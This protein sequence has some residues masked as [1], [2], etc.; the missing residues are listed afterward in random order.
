MCIE[1]LKSK[2]EIE[3]SRRELQRRRLSFTTPWWK[4]LARKT[5]LSRAIDIGDEL[6]SWDVLKTIHFIE[7]NVSK[8]DPILDMGAFA[9]EVLCILRDLGYSN[10]AGIDLN[11]SIKKMPHAESV[12]YNVGDFMHTEF[13]SESFQAISAISVMEHGFNGQKLFA[14]I[15]RL[16]RPGGY[17]IASFDYWPHKLDTSSISF[18]GMSWTIFSEQ[19][20]RRFLDQAGSYQLTPRG[21][22]DLA[23]SER[24]IKCANK[25]YTFGWLVLQK[26]R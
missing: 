14:E 3:L 2:A 9:C 5:G 10:L 17:F 7:R 13:E 8:N 18:F 23:G 22:I 15:S 16:L 11:P 4:K 1:V 21:N 24:P 25:E 20:V 12:H 6:K 19:E 26:C